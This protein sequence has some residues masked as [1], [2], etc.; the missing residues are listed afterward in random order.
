MSSLEKRLAAFRQ[1]PLRAQLAFIASSRTTPELARNPDYIESLKRVHAECLAA[2][3]PEQLKTYEK[4]I[5]IL[6]ASE[7]Q[8]LTAKV[9]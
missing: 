4:A 6:T 2:A 7:T 8:Q 3:T 9:D 5:A 1:L